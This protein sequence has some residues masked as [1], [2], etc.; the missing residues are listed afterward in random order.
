MIR[1]AGKYMYNT[2]AS[3]IGAHSLSSG[4]FTPPARV[5]F[6]TEAKAERDVKRARESCQLF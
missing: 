3:A 2:L 4:H 5:D 1:S 6:A